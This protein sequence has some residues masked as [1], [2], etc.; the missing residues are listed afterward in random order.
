MG[1]NIAN[2]CSVMELIHEN[3][4]VQT[5]EGDNENKKSTSRCYDVLINIK[6]K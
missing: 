4:E 6:V 5:N 1:V 3:V 2:Y